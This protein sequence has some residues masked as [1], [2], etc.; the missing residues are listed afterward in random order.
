M[1][2]TK[3][4]SWSAETGAFEVQLSRRLS[5]RHLLGL[6]LSTHHL[7]GAAD[8]EQFIAGSALSQQEGSTRV[9]LRVCEAPRLVLHGS[10]NKSSVCLCAGLSRVCERGPV[11]LCGPVGPSK[12]LL[13]LQ[14]CLSD[15]YLQK[16]LVDGLCTDFAPAKCWAH[17]FWVVIREKGDVKLN[18][19][20]KKK[21]VE[22]PEWSRL[23][24]LQTVQDFIAF[25]MQETR[26]QLVSYF[27]VRRTKCVSGSAF[28]LL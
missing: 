8:N 18:C 9:W 10:I 22:L 5:W 1:V 4:F 20:P 16:P 3:N 2:K 24:G 28:V 7:H 6:R 12:H 26:F 19:L 23:S 27:E 21:R 25:R 11:W 14:L 15:C 13:I 17:S